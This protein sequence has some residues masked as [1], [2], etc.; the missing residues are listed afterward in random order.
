MKKMMTFA[1]S[2]AVLF[3]TPVVHANNFKIHDDQLQDAFITILNPYIDEA[4]TK[5]LGHAKQ[6]GMYDIQILEIKRPVQQHKHSFEVTVQV[7]TYENAHIPP[8]TTET[9]TFSIDP[10][11]IKEVDFEH[12]GD[13]EGE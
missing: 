12:K 7:K 11:K 4:I 1:C 10:A 9:I 8:F 2:A 3:S 6:Y 13:R 5:H